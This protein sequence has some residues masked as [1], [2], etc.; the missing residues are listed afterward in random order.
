MSLRTPPTITNPMIHNEVIENLQT[1]LS[2]LTWLDHIFPIAEVGEKEVDGTRILLPICYQQETNTV[3]APTN[4]YIE[5]APNDADRGSC[6]FELDNGTGTW[7]RQIGGDDQ[8]DMS[9]SIIFWA[10][11]KLLAPSR[12][13]DFTDE[14]IASAMKALADGTYTNDILTI[15]YQKDRNQV[16]NKYG[17]SYEQLKTFSYPMTAFKITLTM[18]VDEVLSCYEFTD[19]ST[20]SSASSVTTRS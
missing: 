4:N 15:S 12:A 9:I 16:F 11:L 18:P 3:G 8:I 13:Y 1:D 19:F 10:N 7:N 20:S 2:A 17:Y 5:L 14:L 6:F